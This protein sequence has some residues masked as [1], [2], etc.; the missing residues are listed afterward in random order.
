MY[1]AATMK[2]ALTFL[3]AFLLALRV[4]LGADG[5]PMRIELGPPETVLADKALGLRYFPDGRFAVVRTKPDCRAIVSA[6]VSSFLLEGATM[7]KFT[8]ATKV[9]DKGRPGEFDNG[10]A[11]VNAVVRTKAGEL[12]AFYHAED[13]E[14]MKTVGN[15]IPGFYCRVA[16]AVSLDEGATF[17]KRGPVLSGQLI[18]DPNGR[19]DQGVGEPWV[20]AEPKGEFLYAYYTSHER[21]DGRGVQI[22]MARCRLADAL[23]PDAWKKFHMGDFT[24][25]GLGGKDTPVMTSGQPQADALF[26]HVVFA[27]SLR[28]FMMTFCLNVWSEAGNAKR[29]GIY[30]AF[31]DDGIHWPRERMQQIWNVPVIARNGCEVAWHPTYILDGEDGARGWLYYGYSENWGHEP[32]RQPHYMK[33]R[34]LA[35]VGKISKP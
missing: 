25:P 28:Q 2:H 21:V 10:Y 9:L 24:E 27:P 31:S 4:G 22:C 14:T 20:F 26:P 6:G 3:A 13:Q 30:V 33:R 23:K 5:S 17:E 1:N 7:G 8:K 34:S 11:G 12:L 16:L 29:S 19:G 18:K 15:G 32:P 35:I